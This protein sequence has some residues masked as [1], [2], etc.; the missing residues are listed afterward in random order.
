MWEEGENLMFANKSTGDK[1]KK[2]FSETSPHHPLPTIIFCFFFLKKAAACS[3]ND[4]FHN[5][6]SRHRVLYII[7]V[8]LN[9]RQQGII[10][11]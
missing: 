4:S 9:I 2:I 5:T 8:F 11:N 7:Q 6:S 1:K 3:I 10:Y